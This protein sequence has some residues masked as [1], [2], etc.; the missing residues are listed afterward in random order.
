MKH[1]DEAGGRRGWQ[2]GQREPRG[3]AAL[4]APQAGES[5]ALKDYFSAVGVEKEIIFNGN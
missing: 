1:R 3:A 2:G 5:C 4:C